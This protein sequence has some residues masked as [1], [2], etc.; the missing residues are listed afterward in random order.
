M[1]RSSADGALRRPCLRHA[2]VRAGGGP[3][4]HAGPHELHQ[5]GAW[6][7]RHGRRLYRRRADAEIRAL[8][9]LG[10]AGGLS[11]HGRARRLSRAH[12]LRPA[13]RQAASRP[14]HVHHRPR[15]HVGRRRRLFH[16]REPADRQRAAIAGRQPLCGWPLV[17]QV[18]PLRHRL[19]RPPDDRPAARPVEDALRLAPARRGRRRPRGAR[20]RHQ[21]HDHL[22]ADVRLRLRTCRPRR[23]AGKRDLQPRSAIPAEVHDLLPR[24]HRRRRHHD[25]H[26]S[27][28]CIHPARRRGRCGQVLPT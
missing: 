13:L 17:Q 10:P 1:E 12:A 26:R 16:G 23:R 8:A 25:D 7:L 18:P 24:R 22:R 15:L 28:P 20:P 11:R 3:V 19:L 9:V 2:A 5:S 21:R 14:G 4:G 6:R 27:L